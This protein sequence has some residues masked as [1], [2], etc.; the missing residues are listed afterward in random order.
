MAMQYR[1][2][3]NSVAG[4]SRSPSYHVQDDRIQ[5][6]LNFDQAG[7]TAKLV[8]SHDNVKFAPVLS[9]P[10]FTDS[11]V[12]ALD[13]AEGSYIAIEYT[14]AVELSASVMPYRKRQQ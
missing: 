2:L 13:A 3:L 4:S 5:V 6:A 9:L 7:G 12:F 1:Q 14:S 10:E 11:G 8:T